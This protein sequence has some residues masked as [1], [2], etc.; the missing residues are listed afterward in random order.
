L[1]VR[2]ARRLARRLIGEVSNDSPGDMAT[3]ITV[4]FEQVLSRRPTADEL[5]T[6]L[7]FV[8][9][10]M[11]RYNSNASNFGATTTDVAELSEPS[12]NPATRARENLVHVLL[13]HHEF[14]SI[15]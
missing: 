7:G 3:Y 15:R 9:Q 2:E 6:C 12:A 4:A 11:S 5:Q 8:A 10:Q 1:T 13:N 14:V